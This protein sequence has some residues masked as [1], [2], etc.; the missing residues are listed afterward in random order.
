MAGASFPFPTAA[1]VAVGI[2]ADY[3]TV[4]Q[5]EGIVGAHE[6]PASD[7][8]R[9]AVVLAGSSHLDWGHFSWVDSLASLVAWF[10]EHWT[11][12]LWEGC[13]A[14]M[15]WSNLVVHGALLV[16]SSGAGDFDS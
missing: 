5:S 14:S 7:Q 4:A 15:G 6:I 9:D 11:Q 8:P 10:A 16:W 3:Y 13:T 2:D 1:A 12:T